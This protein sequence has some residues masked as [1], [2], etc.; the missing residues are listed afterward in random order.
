[1]AKPLVLL[2]PEPRTRAMI[3]TDDAWASLHEQ[4]DVVAHFGSRMSDDVVERHLG[5]V[6]VI[7]GQT[8][9]PADRLVRAPKLQA[10]V[11]VKGNWEPVIDYGACRARGVQVLSIAP[12]MA[13]AVAEM[14]LGFA[15]ALG[16]NILVND[17]RFREGQDRYGIRG[18]QTAYSLYGAEVGLIG[19]GNLGRALRPLLAPFGCR[20]SVHDPFWPAG[21]LAAEGCRAVG[22]DEVLSTSRFIFILAGV[23]TENEGFL[24]RDRLS[25]IATDASVILV[26]RAEV[27]DFPAFVELAEAGRFRAAIDVFPVEPVPADDPVRRTR[28][29]LLSSHLAGGI[30]DSYRRISDL[31]MDELPLLLRG[32]PS[33]RL[34]R[35][36]PRLAA[37]Q[38]SR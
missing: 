9:M 6:V 24:D 26:S 25:R 10:I 30:F 1:M 35:A 17:R 31:L 23:S 20:V 14:S 7:I 19:F 18:N 16:R 27:T 11:N 2:D 15:I 4:A 28:N 32:L 37:M 3:L 36:D 29:I 21:A 38:R 12:V 8:P 13:P 34:Q 33:L 22:L 5:E